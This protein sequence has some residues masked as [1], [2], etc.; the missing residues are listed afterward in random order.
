MVVRDTDWFFFDS[1]NTSLSCSME[2]QCSDRC[3]WP[4]KGERGQSTLSALCGL[5][6]DEDQTV[7][8]A[9]YV[10]IIVLCLGRLVPRQVKCWQVGSV[11][12]IDWISWIIQQMWLWIERRIVFS[13][14]I[15]IIDEWCVG[16]VILI[17][18]RPPLPIRDRLLS[19]TS[20]V[21]GWQWTIKVLSMSVITTKHEVRRY[22]K[23]GD[24]KGI[25]VAGGHGERR[26]S[27]STQ[28]GPIH[29]FVDGQSTLYVSD[30]V[31]SSCNEMDERGYW[32][33]RRCRWKRGRGGSDTI[34]WSSRSVGGW[35]W[36]CLC[37]RSG[38]SSS[39]ALGEGSKRRNGDR[40]WKWRVEQEAN[41]LSNPEG[42][43][44]DRHG[45]LYVADYGTIIECNVSRSN[46]I[47]VDL[48]LVFSK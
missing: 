33:H 15:K 19:T 28:R 34:V 47:V 31:Q 10:G 4:W 9:D 41:Q 39:D 46:N 16:L 26:R 42:L 17:L 21:R 35:I 13:S 7:Y 22:D 8:I 24:N 5:L 44:F 36:T 38:E 37:G 29:L 11:Q 43:F 12:V 23:G 48:I 25:V 14:A 32:R 30:S 20:I 45:H 6:V 2:D 1:V 18:V 40:R 27:S 3:W